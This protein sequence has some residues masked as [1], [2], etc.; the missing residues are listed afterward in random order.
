MVSRLGLLLWLRRWGSGVNGPILRTVRFSF[1][2]VCWQPVQ[3]WKSGKAD[4]KA[5]SLLGSLT[6][7]HFSLNEVSAERS[8]ADCASIEGGFALVVKGE[9]VVDQGLD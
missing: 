4:L 6:S 9:P 5:K 2:C 8:G 3:V 1:L 7:G